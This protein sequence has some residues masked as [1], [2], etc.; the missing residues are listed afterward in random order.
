MEFPLDIGKLYYYI[1][2]LYGSPIGKGGWPLIIWPY[3]KQTR[4]AR[5]AS[6]YSHH[7]RAWWG[8]TTV[9]SQQVVEELDPTPK[10][11]RHSIIDLIE[12]GFR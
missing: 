2:N 6:V 4:T 5:S 10:L 1:F 3:A 12:K 9:R 7:K 8:A 11:K